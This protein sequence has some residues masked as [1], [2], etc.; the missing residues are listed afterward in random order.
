MTRTAR[1]IATAALGAAVLTAGALTVG[2]IVAQAG[3]DTVQPGQIVTALDRARTG[4]D[5]LPASLV[6]SELGNGGVLATSSRLLATDAGRSFWAAQ[7]AQGDICLI[8]ALGDTGHTIAS[9]CNR[10]HVVKENG[11]LV[12][13]QGFH[14]VDSDEAVAYLLPDAAI[15]DDVSAPWRVLS[16]NVV[17]AASADVKGHGSSLSTTDH[18]S[19]ALVP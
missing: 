18:D 19:I 17:V 2:G 12:G 14:G 15:L 6:L 8:V 11:L 16:D 5:A 3:D 4:G 1:L 7:D 10:P 9:A 13:F